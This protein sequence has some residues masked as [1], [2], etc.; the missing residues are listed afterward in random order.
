MYKIKGQSENGEIE[1]IDEADSKQDAVY[2][3]SEY[4]MAF[5]SNWVI[6]YEN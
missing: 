2:L 4:S 3:V 5:G 6:W 1:V